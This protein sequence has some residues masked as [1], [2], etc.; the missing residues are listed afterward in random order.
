MDLDQRSAVNDPRSRDRDPRSGDA[1][2]RSGDS[3]RRPGIPRAQDDLFRPGVSARAK[4][5]ALVVGRPGLGALLRHELVVLLAQARAGAAG[6]V[7]RKAL[8]P[9]LL[10]ASGRNVV[11]GQN[12]VLRHP[13]KI[14]VGDV[15]RKMSVKP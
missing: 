9:L 7:L 13:H 3:D 10:G 4:Y 2:R 8:Y 5:Q 15:I 6:L 14:R 11:F 1:A 12:V